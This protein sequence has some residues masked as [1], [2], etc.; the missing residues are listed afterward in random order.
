MGFEYSHSWD[1]FTILINQTGKETLYPETDVNFKATS[2]IL[3]E[4]E[5]TPNHFAYFLTLQL[6]G[7][8]KM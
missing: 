4:T 5:T 8:I 7:H 1:G 3:C 2:S 6:I